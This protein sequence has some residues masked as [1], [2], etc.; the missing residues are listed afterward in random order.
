MKAKKQR[1]CR[2]SLAA[3]RAPNW[4][5]HLDV[6]LIPKYILCENPVNTVCHPNYPCNLPFLSQY[7][8][9]QIYKCYGNSNCSIINSYFSMLLV[10]GYINEIMNNCI[11]GNRFLSSLA[12][13]KIGNRDT[14]SI[15]QRIGVA[16]GTMDGIKERDTSKPTINNSYGPDDGHNILSDSLYSAQVFNV[17]EN[18]LLPP[19]P[20]AR[21]RKQ[22]YGAIRPLS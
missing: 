3:V 19:E 10:H 9:C 17:L 8:Y 14:Q 15:C 5:Y 7:T 11:F 1:L 20:F 21:E 16:F 4:I 22:Y 12:H 2:G 6:L 13:N 18:T